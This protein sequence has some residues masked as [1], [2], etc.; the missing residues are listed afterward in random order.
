MQ[1]DT[2]RWCQALLIWNAGMVFQYIKTGKQKRKGCTFLLSDFLEMFSGH[3]F[4]FIY[5]ICHDI[6]GLGVS[7]WISIEQL[8]DKGNAP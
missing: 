6:F 2:A 3:S 4:L 7:V 1:N 8:C 5:N